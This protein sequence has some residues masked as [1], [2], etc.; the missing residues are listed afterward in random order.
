VL[1]NPSDTIS[2]IP[3]LPE[4]AYTFMRLF[5]RF[6][7]ALKASGF[8]TGEGSNVTVDWLG[9]VRARLDA[10]FAQTFLQDGAGGTQP[11]AFPLIRATPAEPV[12]NR[13]H[14]NYLNRRTP[15]DEYELIRAVC[16]LHD[17]L[18]HECFFP[19]EHPL[20]DDSL[21]FSI[22]SAID[23]LCHAL[24]VDDALSEVFKARSS[25]SSG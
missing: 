15:T 10:S 22:D 18:L 11:R 23:I 20:Y 3:E 7:Y 2:A 25:R 16:F 5:Q 17:N 24:A 8:A 12:M 21:T 13:G 19:V 4:N 9:Y 6:K 1:E 14:L